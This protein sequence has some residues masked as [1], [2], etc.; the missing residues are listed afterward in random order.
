MRRWIWRGLLVA[1]GLL[2]LLAVPGGV[3]TF[4]LACA[5]SLE[6]YQILASVRTQLAATPTPTPGVTPTAITTPGA[7]V[8]P[9]ATGVP[10][11]TPQ[12]TATSAPPAPAAV[13]ADQPLP[14]DVQRLPPIVRTA[15]GSAIGVLL[16]VKQHDAFAY[17]AHV[18]MAHG[19]DVAGCGE[20]AVRIQWLKAGLHAATDGQADRVARALAGSA[21]N[22]DD[23]VQMRRIV[24]YWADRVPQSVGIRR[25]QTAFDPL[26]Y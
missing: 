8:Q 2:L 5:G 15:G 23:L 19:L 21:Q 11:A 9:G 20:D 12:P 7:G 22:R 4:T 18:A 26:M 16:R 3:K 10:T 24:D 14:V 17:P 6:G 25:V 1:L 13:G